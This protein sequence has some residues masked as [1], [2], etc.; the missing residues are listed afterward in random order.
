M[1]EIRTLNNN[2]KR[3]KLDVQIVKTISNNL[4]KQPENTERKCKANVQYMPREC[5]EVTCKPK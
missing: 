5:E 1:T 3:L 2:F 4:L